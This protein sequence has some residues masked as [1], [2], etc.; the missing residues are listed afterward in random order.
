MKKSDLENG[1]IVEYRNG[2]KY[3]VIKDYTD[4][5]PITQRKCDILLGINIDGYDLLDYYNEDLEMEKYKSLRNERDIVRVWA[6]KSFRQIDDNLMLL[7]ERENNADLI[8][9]QLDNICNIFKVKSYDL[10]YDNNIHQIGVNLLNGLRAEVK[11][12]DEVLEKC[13]KEN[14]IFNQI[15]CA[16]SQAIRH[17][18]QNKK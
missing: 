1:M 16:I 4:K 8:I 11:I 6:L 13:D 9:S 7:W 14:Y 17:S 12:S 5:S 3:I 15:H 10:F 2:D 18:R